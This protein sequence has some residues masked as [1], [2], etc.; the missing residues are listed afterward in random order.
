MIFSFIII[1]IL[2]STA[3]FFFTKKKSLTSVLLNFSIYVF[4]SVFFWYSLKNVFMSS[5]ILL[6]GEKLVAKIEKTNQINRTEKYYNITA[7]TSKYV[8]TDHFINILGFVDSS[9]KKHLKESSL[10]TGDKE[11]LKKIEIV[12]SRK[13]DAIFELRATEYF[14]FCVTIIIVIT[15]IFYIRRKFAEIKNY[16]LQ[17]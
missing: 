11:D 1:L 10:A 17:Q 4:I 6:T 8:T 13:Y 12:Y 2:A 5:V 16:K 7:N 3:T 14:F 15:T 9:G